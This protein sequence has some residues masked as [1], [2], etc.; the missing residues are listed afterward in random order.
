MTGDS[1]LD[2]SVFVDKLDDSLKADQAAL[3][4]LDRILHGLG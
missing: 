3:A 2:I 1:A 4:G